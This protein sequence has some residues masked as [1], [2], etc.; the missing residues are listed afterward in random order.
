MS[1]KRAVIVHG[2][3]GRPGQHWTAWLKNKLEERGYAVLEPAMPDS[4]H[5]AIG[6][7]VNHLAACVGTLDEN[8]FFVGHSIGGQTILRYLQTQAGKKAGGCVFVA[9]WF[10]LENL[11]NEASELIAKPWLEENIDF[12]TVL[13]TTKNFV[14]INSSNDDY[15]FVEDNKKIFE[16]KLKAQVIILENKGHLTEADGVTQLPEVLEAIENFA[17][18]P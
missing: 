7:W 16:E 1:K 12:V 4:D 9:G 5:P 8:T 13:A 3:G 17:A 14:V 15:G 2:W 6:A 10:K 18:R 11:E